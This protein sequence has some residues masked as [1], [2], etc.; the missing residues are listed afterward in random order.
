[1]LPPPATAAGTASEWVEAFADGW[2]APTD[3]DSFCHHFEPYLSDSIRLVQPQL[4]EV[5]GKAAFR[6][7]FAR[8]LFELLSEIRGEVGAWAST[9]T[10]DGEVVLIE[11]TI[12]A[13]VGGRPVTL[14]TVDKITLRD[15]LAVERIAI[16]DPLELLGAVA[17][18]PR[19]WPR[20][21]R[22]QLAGLRERLAR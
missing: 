1:M 21:A 2:R 16:L 15:G 22:V 12:R 6:E 7:R 9:P 13:R 10:A 3:A 19:A 8:P 20:F 17:L 14:H 5:V 11:L 4:P 18:S